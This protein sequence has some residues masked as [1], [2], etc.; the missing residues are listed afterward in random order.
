M[1][2]DALGSKNEIIMGTSVY[3]PFLLALL[4]LVQAAPEKVM[5]GEPAPIAAEGRQDPEAATET[6]AK[7]SRKARVFTFPG[8]SQDSRTH[9][10]L[11]VIPHTEDRFASAASGGGEDDENRLL[12]LLPTFG[13][14]GMQVGLDFKLPF[15]SIPY[16]KMF[17]A[18]S[19][20]SSFF[21]GQSGLQSFGSTNL[22]GSGNSGLATAAAMAVT[23][24][25][26][27]PKVSGMLGLGGKGVFRDGQGS[28]DFLHNMNS[29][30]SQ[31]N[32]DGEACMKVALCSLGN[33]RRSKPRGRDSSR[34][35][36]TPADVVEDILNLPSVKGMLNKGGLVQARDF[37]GSG[38]D[39]G[40]F[41]GQGKCPVAA[42]T[43][44]DF[45]AKL[46]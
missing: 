12:S 44:T 23:A 34:G 39:C 11:Y 35:T 29:V 38:G 45:L 17:S 37:G 31:F 15:F 42:K 7:S 9:Q 20:P 21:P 41:D 2:Q 19:S 26:L 1:V 14:D 5:F 6:T 22:L 24:A 3:I 32:I 36:T 18:L 16:G 4:V 28:D 27:Y 43:F 30:L 33:A 25:L 13:N 40:Y 10:P 8:S 46:G